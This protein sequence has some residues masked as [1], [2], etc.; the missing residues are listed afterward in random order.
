MTQKAYNLVT[1][2]TV[3]AGETVRIQLTLDG[4]WGIKGGVAADVN[5]AT[6]PAY[7]LDRL[8]PNL[9]GIIGTVDFWYSSSPDDIGAPDYS[10]ANITIVNISRGEQGYVKGS[11]TY[12]VID[13]H[14]SF[15]DF[16]YAYAEPRGGRLVDGILNPDP[17][18]D[19]VSLAD[20]QSLANRCMA[21]MGAGGGAPASLSDIDP[22]RDLQWMGAH[23]ATEL[24]KLMQ[25]TGHVYCPHSS[26]LG[27][28][29]KIGSSDLPT[30]PAERLELDIIA[31]CV[32]RRPSAAIYL[33]APTPIISTCDKNV[34]GDNAPTW[35]YVAQDPSD[36]LKW[37]PLA[38]VPGLGGSLANAV[39]A[40]KNAFQ[41]VDPKY[42][43]K[44]G[45][46]VFKCIR[47][48]SSFATPLQ[49]PLL[50]EV[51]Y[52]DQTTDKPF[53]E[54][55]AAVQEKASGAWSN[56]TVRLDA[57]AVESK[58]NVLTFKQ[59]IGQVDPAEAADFDAYFKLIPENQLKPT[60]SM[61]AW[62]FDAGTKKFGC[63][64]FTLSLGI[65]SPLDESTAR[66]YLTGYRPN[67]A[68]YCCSEIRE[69]GLNGTPD[70]A[71]PQAIAQKYAQSLLAS[72][73]NTRTLRVKGFYAAQI[74]GRVSEIRLDPNQLHT[75]IV[76][77]GWIAASP[78]QHAPG[79][80]K[81]KCSAEPENQ[82][83]DQPVKQATR[84]LGAAAD[85]SAEKRGSLGNT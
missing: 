82:N 52:Q 74:S 60:Y 62:D 34:S 15:A 22:P 70:Y 45:D 16:R 33:T 83:L 3:V 56:K 78:A 67:V 84:T 66:S 77:D 8:G 65:V 57:E 41:D 12:Q 21:A 81:A 75:E 36:G 17:L 23:A 71:T 79:S 31:P 37:K 44:I 28:V 27:Y 18:P 50:R 68:V 46:Q 13:W 73:P 9:Y 59:R 2:T 38:S 4:V 85:L 80:A 42:Q 63:Y 30:P 40:V 24:G 6:V 69:V 48:K 49:A 54:I 53:I 29:A 10:I 26:G 47:L 64:G 14:V 58:D 7:E 32:D 35:E 25:H 51:I 72:T 1:F 20:C 61:E 11:D 19:G 5:S 43:K 76:I 55:N 39:K